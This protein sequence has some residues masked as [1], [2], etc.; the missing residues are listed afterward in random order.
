MRFTPQLRDL[1]WLVE[2]PIAHRGLHNKAAGI[3][4]NTE[5]AFAGAIKGNYAIECDLQISADGEAMVFHDATL[6][7]LTGDVGLVRDHTFKQLQKLTIGNGKDYMQTLG[8]LL[9]QVDGKVTLVIEMKS[10]WDGNI[11]LAQKALQVLKNYQEPYALMSFDPDLMAAVA[12][13]SP[14]T[15]RGITADRAVDSNYSRLPLARRIAMRNFEHLAATRPHFVSYYF[16]D[17]PFPAIQKIRSAGHPVIS[18]TIRNQEQE[19]L[20][21]R[22][23]DQI[24]FEGYAA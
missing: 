12:E 4:E 11:A 22:W 24:T 14:H 7:R 20:A 21:R 9:E 5:S 16:R 15:V 19:S 17:M 23:S 13:L 6:Q 3:W 1:K 10:H 8:E 18:W 2:R